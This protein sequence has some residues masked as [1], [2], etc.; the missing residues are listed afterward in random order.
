MLL[1]NKVL[2]AKEANVVNLVLK[3]CLVRWDPVVSLV[4][5]D[6]PVFPAHQVP[7]EFQESLDQRVTWDLKENL[8]LLDNRVLLDHKVFQVLKDQ[9]VHLE[10]RDHPES[11]AC[12]VFLVLMDFQDTPETRVPL[13]L[14]D[15]WEDPD[16]KDPRDILDHEVLR[17]KVASEESRVTR[18]TRALMA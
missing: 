9:W 3:V 13:D 12:L 4:S 15:L 2:M 14:K 11:L 17:E 7:E 18:E 1:E 5:R 16:H 10:A 8:V 6:H